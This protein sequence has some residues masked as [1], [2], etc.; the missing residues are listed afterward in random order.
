M[1]DCVRLDRE[2]A[3]MCAFAAEAMS[4]NSPFAQQICQ[5]CAE[6]CEA[7]GNECKNTIMLIVRSVQR[8]VSDVQRHVVRWPANILTLNSKRGGSFG[9]ASFLADNYD[10][11]LTRF[12]WIIHCN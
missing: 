3:D 10:F 5:L 11:M 8:L 1:A 2:C 12:V 6:I 7:C 4:R 9:S